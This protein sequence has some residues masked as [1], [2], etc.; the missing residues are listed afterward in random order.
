MAYLGGLAGIEYVHEVFAL[1]AARNFVE[2][3]WDESGPTLA[4]PPGLDIAAYRVALMARFANPA[5]EHRTR[6]IAMDGSQK[7]PQ[8]LLA[9]IAERRAQGLPVDTLALAVAAWMRWQGGRADDGSRFTVDDPLAELT[10]AA[11]HD[12]PRAMVEALTAITAIFP[13]ALAD[14]ED[15]KQLLAAQLATLSRQGALAAFARY[16]SRSGI[17]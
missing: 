2:A 11:V 14:D 7:L 15:L 6:Q 5:L 12:D 13:P 9:P 8:R 16:T 17:S 3:L 4:P 1:P 10:A